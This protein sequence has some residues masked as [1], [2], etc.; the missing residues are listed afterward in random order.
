MS[1][2][3]PIITKQVLKRIT[4]IVLTLTTLSMLLYDDFLQSQA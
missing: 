4:I 1:P 2:H 3:F